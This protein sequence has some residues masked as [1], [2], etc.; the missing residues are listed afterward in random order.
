MTDCGSSHQ[1]QLY[2]LQSIS[3]IHSHIQHHHRLNLIRVL[4]WILNCLI[5]H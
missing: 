5:C 3:Q 1:H 4:I 2:M